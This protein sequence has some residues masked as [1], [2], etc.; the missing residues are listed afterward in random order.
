MTEGTAY[1][2]YIEPIEKANALAEREYW[3][4]RE[5][6]SWDREIARL[7]AQDEAGVRPGPLLTPAPHGDLWRVKKDRYGNYW[8]TPI[9]F[10]TRKVLGLPRRSMDSPYRPY[11]QEEERL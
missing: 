9:D 3:P 5:P 10:S 6:H 8:Y 4:D 1:E 7:R 2:L 11:H